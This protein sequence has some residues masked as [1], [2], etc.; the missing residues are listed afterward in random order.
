MTESNCHIANLFLTH[1][2]R[3]FVSSIWGDVF[4]W[5]SGTVAECMLI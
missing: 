1:G 4:R 3:L 2:R 5:V